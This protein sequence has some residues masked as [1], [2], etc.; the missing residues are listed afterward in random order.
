MKTIFLLLTIGL[1]P[2]AAMTGCSKPGTG[3][4]RSAAKAAAAPV[5]TKEEV[6]AVVGQHVTSVEGSGS[7]L[8]YKTDV[9]GFETS[10][11]LEQKG[12]IDDAIQSL[13]GARTATGIL[14]GKPEAVPHLGDDAFFGAMSFLYVRKGDAFITI[15]PPNLQMV[16]GMGAAQQVMN[17]KLGSDEQIKAMANLQQV[18][19]TDPLNAGL[20]GGDDVQGAL[21][22]VA[23]AS[24]KQGTDYEAQARTMA[25]ALATKLLEKM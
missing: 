10:I 8:T 24:K 3:G 9:M 23:A 18:E 12:G 5:L 13:Q 6:S 20:K 22:V 4:G 7:S 11:E 16:A 17:A 2:A 14:G 21:A 25:V 19:K 1:L 15:T